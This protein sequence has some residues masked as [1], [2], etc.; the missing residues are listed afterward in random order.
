MVTTRIFRKVG[1]L[2][3][4]IVLVLAGCHRQPKVSLQ[5]V[6]VTGEASIRGILKAPDTLVVANAKVRVSSTNLGVVREVLTASDGSFQLT[7]LPAGTDYSMLVTAKGF[8]KIVRGP[9]A[10]SRETQLN[11]L[12]VI[13]RKVYNAPTYYY[14]PNNARELGGTTTIYCEPRTGEPVIHYY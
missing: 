13:G 9:I 3:L 5:S 6:G 2:S 12:L 8:Y 7:G 14:V 10:L 1:R 11:L 4:A